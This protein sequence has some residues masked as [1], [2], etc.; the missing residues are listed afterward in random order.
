MGGRDEKEPADQSST[1]VGKISRGHQGKKP[2]TVNLRH[3]PL[4]TE[5]CL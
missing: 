4:L 2:V 1:Y 3:I 5:L